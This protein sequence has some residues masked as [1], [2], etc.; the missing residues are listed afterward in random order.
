MFIGVY[1]QI[2]V[3]ALGPLVMEQMDMNQTQLANVMMAPLL[4]GV[5]LSVPLGNLADRF[6]VFRVVG[7]ALLGTIIG[8]VLR[9]WAGSFT[10]AFL[11]ML[12]IGAGAAAL[13]ANM[14]KLYAAWFKPQDMGKA[15]GI[16]MVGAAG[17]TGVAQMTGARFGSIQ[18]AFTFCA[19]ATAVAVVYFLLV[20]RDRPKGAAAPARERPSLPAEPKAKG[21]LGEVL[22]NPHAW[23][24]ALGMASFNAWQMTVATFSPTWLHLGKDMELATA[25]SYA[26]AFA[27]GGLAG[28]IICPWIAAR[29]HVMKPVVMVG[30]FLAGVFTIVAWFF[31]PTIGFIV[32]I[33]LSGVGGAAVSNLVTPAP[34]LLPSIGP[35]RAGTAG[36]LMATVGGI[37]G[38]AYPSLFVAP[39]SGD[40]YTLQ[41]ILGGAAAAVVLFIMLGVPEYAAGRVPQKDA[42]PPKQAPAA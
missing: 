30:G 20:V 12:L 40:N 19:V 1:N 14:A 32:F 36:G 41:A 22:R 33:C 5:F 23:L 26:S 10:T 24:V 6:G 9:I 15:V 37:V 34:A 13:G 27:W 42:P 28:S 3:G 29:F 21:V 35:A 4:G 2:V 39:I 25:G 16:A 31:A 11:A 18:L 17:G 7:V 38:Y 8:A